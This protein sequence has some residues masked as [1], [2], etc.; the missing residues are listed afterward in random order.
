MTDEEC[1][2]IKKKCVEEVRQALK[3]ITSGEIYDRKGYL[4]EKGY[5][6]LE[7]LEGLDLFWICDPKIKL[8]NKTNSE[9]E[10][11]K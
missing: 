6:A 2:T 5:Q 8:V 4:N 1:E 3:T 10:V 9:N 11:D 7:Q